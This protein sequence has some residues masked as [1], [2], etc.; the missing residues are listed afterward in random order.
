[1]GLDG[2]D[3]HG[4]AKQLENA[5]I[6]FPQSRPSESLF[7]MIWYYSTFYSKL[8]LEARNKCSTRLPIKL[9]QLGVGKLNTSGWIL[10]KSLLPQ[11]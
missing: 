6:Y 4:L 10:R 9:L 11:S 2:E 5:N 3:Y 8:S 1:M 7:D